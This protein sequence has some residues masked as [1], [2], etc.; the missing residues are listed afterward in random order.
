MSETR[1]R[2]SMA[3]SD[4]TV[5]YLSL[6]LYRAMPRNAYAMADPIR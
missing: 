1:A 6:S 4:Y 3:P 2:H 5:E